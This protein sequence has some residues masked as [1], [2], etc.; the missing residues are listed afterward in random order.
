MARLYSDFQEKGGDPSLD[1][2]NSCVSQL[3]GEVLRNEFGVVQQISTVSREVAPE[4]HMN[5]NP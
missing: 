5:L 4:T 1:V 3:Q 2:D